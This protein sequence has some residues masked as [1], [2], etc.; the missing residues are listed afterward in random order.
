MRSRRIWCMHTV[1]TTA[2]AAVVRDAAAWRPPIISDSTIRLRRR[3]TLRVGHGAASRLLYVSVCLSVSVC[4]MYLC[5]LV[6]PSLPRWLFGATHSETS[7]CSAIIDGNDPDL[8]SYALQLNQRNEAT[9]ERADVSQL[10]CSD[11]V[12]GCL[13]GLLTEWILDG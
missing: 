11:I 12:L 10:T 6:R 9:S 8:I 3:S 7:Y 2:T 1:A 4:S 5:I 13:N